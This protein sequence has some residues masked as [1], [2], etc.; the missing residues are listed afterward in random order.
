MPYTTP[1]PFTLEH[2]FIHIINLQAE[3]RRQG[4]NQLSITINSSIVE[5]DFSPETSSLILT[6][7]LDD[8]PKH[9]SPNP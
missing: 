9:P 4:L 2:I 7:L 3:L 6:K 1:V 8:V 5:L